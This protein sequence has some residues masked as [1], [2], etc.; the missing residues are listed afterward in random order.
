MGHD[1][2]SHQRTGSGNDHA[3]GLYY[4]VVNTHQICILLMYI[5]IRSRV[6]KNSGIC[7]QIR[8]CY[9]MEKT[10]LVR[11]LALMLPDPKTGITEEDV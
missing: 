9:T 8:L 3:A 4:S 6:S 10:A 5:Y 1:V 7:F 2:I 11:L